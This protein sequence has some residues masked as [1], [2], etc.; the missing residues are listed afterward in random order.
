[1][2]APKAADLIASVPN[3]LLEIG[4]LSEPV[5]VM[6]GGVIYKELFLSGLTLLDIK[7]GG[8]AQGGEGAPALTLS[9]V[10][11]RQEVRDLVSALNLPRR[12]VV[13]PSA[14]PAIEEAMPDP[15]AAE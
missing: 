3:P 10:A 7:R 6:R 2:Q 9:H 13:E 11:A 4:L 5:F 14:E 12:D 15:Q 8:G 1:M